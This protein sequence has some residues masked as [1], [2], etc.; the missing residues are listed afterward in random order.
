MDKERI[1]FELRLKEKERQALEMLA[2]KHGVSMS[3]LVAGYIRRKAKTEKVWP[4]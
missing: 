1:R 4:Q 3:N 2:E